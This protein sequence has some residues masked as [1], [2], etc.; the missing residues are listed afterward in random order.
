MESRGEDK[1]DG[2]PRKSGGSEVE[3]KKSDGVRKVGCRGDQSLK[4]RTECATREA[5][6]EG[7]VG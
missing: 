1:V 2:S 6:D 3:R 7:E 4:G 5:R